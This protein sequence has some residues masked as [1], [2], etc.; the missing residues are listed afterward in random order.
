MAGWI[1]LT[2]VPLFLGLFA[3]TRC[4]PQNKGKKKAL[5]AFTIAYPQSII[6]CVLFTAF[7]MV[8]V[9]AVTYYVAPDVVTACSGYYVVYLVLIGAV[10]GLAMMLAR[11][12]ISFNGDKIE[13]ASGRMRK[14]AVYSTS[15]LYRLDI[16]KTAVRALKEDGTRLF[17]AGVMMENLDLFFAWTHERP[18]IKLTLNGK[19]LPKKNA[20]QDPTRKPN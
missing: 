10:M 4:R 20:P 7:A 16:Q 18:N 14:P 6:N 15:E 11:R 1:L 5:K 2:F 12:T 19:E 8:A 3:T 13:V 9:V 17:S